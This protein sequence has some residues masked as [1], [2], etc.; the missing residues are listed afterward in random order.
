MTLLAIVLPSLLLV[1]ALRRWIWPVPWRIA[2]LFLVLTLVFLHGA[3]F[4]SKLP[5]PLD[6]AARPYPWR[7]IFGELSPRNGSTNDAATLFLPW[8]HAAREELRHFRAPLWNRYSF[9][10]YP[11]LGNGESAPF[12]PLFL[13]TLFVRLPKQIVAMAGLKIFVALLFTFLLMKRERAGDAAAIFAAIAFAWSTVMAIFLYY[14]FASVVA[15]LPAAAFALLHAEDEPRK[16]NIVFVAL[17]VGTLLANGHP[18]SVLHVAIGCGGLLV[19]DFA[20]SADRRQWVRR[21]GA[22]LVGVIVGLAISAPAWVPGLEQVL[23]SERMT[24]VRSGT[25]V[26]G[27]PPT[28]AWA[29]VMPNGFG[30][31]LRHNYSWWIG[32]GRVAFSYVGLLPLVL[33]L[34]A[35]IA[36]R[37]SMRDRAIGALAIALFLIA[38][39]WTVVGRLASSLPGLSHATNEK[40]RFVSLFLVAVVA[41]K[42]L[43]TSRRWIAVAAVPVLLLAGYVYVIKGSVLRPIDILGIATMLVFLAVES[44]WAALLV[45]VELFVLNAGF[46]ALVEPRFYRPRL[47]IIGAIRAR[48]PQ[49]P[50]RVAA[51]GFTFSPNASAL[52]ELEDIR[53]SD[54]MGFA[55]YDA[56]LGRFTTLDAPEVARRVDDPGRP[57]L[58]F[59]NVR[60][61]MTDPAV[62]PGGRWEEIYRGVDGVLFENPG[63]RPRFFSSAARVEAIREVAPAEF[64]M[65]VAAPAGATVVSSE[66]SAPGRRVV[67]NGRE[68][69]IRLVEGAF[70]GF[71]VPSG[72]SVVRLTYR[73]MSFWAA[74]GVALLAA[75]VLALPYRGIQR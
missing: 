10:G 41:A 29:I 1:A 8:M 69:P 45:A 67:V 32:Y 28:A 50:F 43:D 58:D 34:A 20:F 66:V 52:Y 16:A 53:G 60:Y 25:L 22:P 55:S 15:F 14:S 24:L 44:K 2:I 36:P 42:V 37:T 3:V 38:M 33:F 21:F 4:T 12:S 7:G 31:P 59:L 61:L 27:I 9:S 71:Q 62:V 63:V 39:D 74:V 47:P 56:Y 5:I 46:N 54:P 75:I 18:E 17:I 70:I 49:E 48:A 26:G 72:Q 73:P 64:T 68:V 30:N 35:L 65:W 19:I 40:L 11:L 51:T 23:L 13:V 6:D 57:E